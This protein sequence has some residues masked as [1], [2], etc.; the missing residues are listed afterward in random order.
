MSVLVTWLCT[1]IEAILVAIDL[2]GAAKGNL[3]D[4]IVAAIIFVMFILCLSIAIKV[5]IEEL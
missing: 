2:P 1:T 3:I 5:T 4:I